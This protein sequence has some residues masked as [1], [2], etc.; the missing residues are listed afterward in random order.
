MS[1]SAAGVKK[2]APP[3]KKACS[4]CTKAK[5]RCDLKRPSCLRCQ[6]RSLTCHY[7][8]PDAQNLGPIIGTETDTFRLLGASA[9]LSPPAANAVPHENGQAL[10]VS[11]QTTAS[12][13]LNSFTPND[14]GDPSQQAEQQRATGDELDFSKTFLISKTDSKLIRDR[15]MGAFLPSSNQRPKVLPTHTVQYLSCVLRSFSRQ[16]L[17]P[18]HYP[19]IIHP[20]QMAGEV[21]L[22]LA[23][24][25]SLIRM[26]EG[27]AHG[28]E[29]IVAET[30]QR[31]MNRLYEEVGH[32]LERLLC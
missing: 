11:N 4:Q 8:T 12:S 31:E 17:R 18:G 30:V 14:N 27:Q 5:V 29:G 13:E 24:C 1:D 25:F 22:P 9:G 10:S 7:S 20:T 2:T 26:W 3:R 23:N 15:W 19:P 21:P 16:M 6:S 28:S 32:L